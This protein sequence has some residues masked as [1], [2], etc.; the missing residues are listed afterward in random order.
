MLWTLFINIFSACLSA[1][2]AATMVHIVIILLTAV[3]V[4]VIPCYEYDI[5]VITQVR[6]EAEYKC[7]LQNKI[8]IL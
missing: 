2:T 4:I 7:Y 1:A 8:N 6:G 5:V 3:Y